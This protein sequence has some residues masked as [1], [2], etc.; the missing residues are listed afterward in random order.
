MAEVAVG[1]LRHM[2]AIE[3][4]FGSHFPSPFPQFSS[5]PSTVPF[6][7]FPFPQRKF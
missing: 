4:S 2:C 6:M 3:I 7:G 1:E 5:R